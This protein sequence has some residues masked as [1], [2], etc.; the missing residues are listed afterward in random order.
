MNIDSGYPFSSPEYRQAFPVHGESDM[1]INQ[2]GL[3]TH[4]SF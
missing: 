2:A 3:L 1:S 4:G